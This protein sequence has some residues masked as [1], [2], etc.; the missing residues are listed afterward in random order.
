[1]R[2]RTTNG[3]LRAGRIPS[4]ERPDRVRAQSQRRWDVQPSQI[5]LQP[6][7][8]PQ[9]TRT[10]LLG[11]VRQPVHRSARHKQLQRPALLRPGDHGSTPLLLLGFSNLVTVLS[12]LFNGLFID[13]FG[14]RR[15]ILTGCCG[16]PCE[17]ALTARFVETGS[18]DR[19][20]LGFV[21]FIFAYVAFYSSCLDTTMYL[22]PLEI[23]PMVIVVN[24]KSRSAR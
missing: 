9:T 6:K 18:A 13:R 2:L 15:F 16:I 17:A 11:A 10:G 3:Q 23:F 21:F 14:R 24:L 5:R 1:M 22:V 8:L 12:N 20:G 7:E 4:N 19:V